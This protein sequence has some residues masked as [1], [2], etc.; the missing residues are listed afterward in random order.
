MNAFKLMAC[1][2]V[3]TA[4]F[5]S[6]SNDKTLT[7]TGTPLTTS[8][9][10][11]TSSDAAGNL[12][13]Q[14][15]TLSIDPANGSKGVTRVLPEIK[16]TFDEAMNRLG[17]EAGIKITGTIQGPPTATRDLKLSMPIT[18]AWNVDETEMT[19]KLGGTLLDRELVT[20]IVPRGTPTQ[21][22]SSSV[23]GFVGTKATKKASFRAAQSGSGV[24]IAQA[25]GCVSSNNVVD[26]DLTK[27]YVGDFPG[28][29]FNRCFYGFDLNQKKADLVTPELPLNDIKRIM[30]GTTFLM[31]VRNIFNTPNALGPELAHGVEYGPTIGASDFGL[32]PTTIGPFQGMTGGLV[33]S[34]DVQ[35]QISQAWTNRA[36]NG[37]QAQLR[38]GF[39]DGSVGSF[40]KDGFEYEGIAGADNTIKPRV[41]VEF[42]TE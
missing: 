15:L 14:N 33:Q 22:P 32:L 20:V 28:G 23:S 27:T 10:Q 9:G 13:A 1:A 39:T 18:Y 16:V 12:Q 24:L 6:C 29:S 4:I 17:T 19:V 36:L 3:L 40:L 5:A 7:E 8:V 38:L 34:T 41:L 26:P 37:S 35:Q 2:T 11:P 21:R 30:S 42:E 25:Q 31:N